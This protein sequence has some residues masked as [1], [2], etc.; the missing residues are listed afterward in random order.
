RDVSGEGVQQA[1]L[2]LVEGSRVTLNVKENRSSRS[3]PPITTNYNSGGSSP[4]SS[5]SSPPQG[6]VDQYTID[7]SNILFIM[8]GAFVGLRSIVERR[9]SKPS[10]GF[11]SDLRGRQNLSGDKHDLPKHL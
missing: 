5:Q 3:T 6:K 7:T 1:L 4:S 9:V 8:C 2:K 10:M 11:G